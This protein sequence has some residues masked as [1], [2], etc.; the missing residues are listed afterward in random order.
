MAPL[1]AVAAAFFAAYFG[2]RSISG[3]RAVEALRPLAAAAAARSSLDPNV[4]LAVVVLESGG[5]PAARSAAGAIGLAQLKLPAA[6]DAA[7][8]L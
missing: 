8:R 3:V 5:D 2:L 6:A 7:R 4:L 1:L